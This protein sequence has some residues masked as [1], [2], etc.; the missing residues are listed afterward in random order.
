ML[1][2]AHKLVSHA[3]VI[4]A[5]GG[6]KPLAEAIGVEPKRAIHWSRRGIPAKYWPLIE[7][8]G[9]GRGTGIT[10]LELSR[11]PASHPA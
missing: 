5:F 4:E 8:V 6:T 3:A 7:E 10:A 9:R 11:L 2:R 1:S